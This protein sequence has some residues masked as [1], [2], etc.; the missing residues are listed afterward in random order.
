MGYRFIRLVTQWLL[1]LTIVS[2]VLL[3]MV[4]S[5]PQKGHASTATSQQNL[6]TPTWWSGNCDSNNDPGSYP[7]GASY[8]GVEAC[9]PIGRMH[10]VQFFPNAWGEYEWQ[11]TELVFRYL[12]LAYNVNPY[13]AYGNQVVSNY[14]IY[15]PQGPLTPVSNKGVPNVLPSDGDVLSYDGTQNNPHG[16]SSIVTSVSVNSSG[17]GTISVIE[18]NGTSNGVDQVGVSNWK[19]IIPYKSSQLKDVNGWLHMPN[20]GSEA[21]HNPVTIDNLDGRMEIFQVGSDGQL[22][23]QSENGNGNWQG[24]QSLGGNWPNQPAVAINPDGR[25]E[26]FAVGDQ[27]KSG[28]GLFHAWQTRAGDDTSWT[29]WQMMA[30]AWPPGTPA[31]AMN[32]ANEL[33]VFMRGLDTNLYHEW[34]TSP[35]N[36]SS[37]TGWTPMGGYWTTDPVVGRNADGSLEVFMVGESTQLYYDQ[38]LSSGWSGWQSLGGSWPGQPTVILNSSNE[39]EVFIV[40]N[41]GS[42]GGGLFH[43]WQISP[44]NTSW[45]G[46]N[47]LPGGWHAGSPFV[48]KNGNGTMD[49][50]LVGQG[51]E[52]NGNIALY[53]DY[54][55]PDGTWSGPQ[56]LGGYWLG[57]PS[58]TTNLSGGL[59]A[60]ML[61]ESG[62]VYHAW[63]NNAGDSSSYSGWYTLGTP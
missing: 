38:R 2:V 23:Y 32:S 30:S 34:Q 60:F 49:V 18:E 25:L 13:K 21:V 63:Q 51:E 19:L 8:Q 33:E 58:V 26:I 48:A 44:E 4:G 39:L 50:F 46:W 37:Y 47:M 43:A 17:Y 1:T 9:G 61:G 40:G 10:E 5:I 52:N 24:W 42:S 56:S 22:Y 28:G 27:G 54:E 35:G 3:L 62:E 15:N 55:N 41:Q 20:Q 29:G 11:C 57:E 6:P 31:V 45:T 16:H 36:S 7:L 12:Y 59:E 14:R 53:H